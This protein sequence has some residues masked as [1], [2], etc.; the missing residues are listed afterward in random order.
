[1]EK[2]KILSDEYGFSIF[3]QVVGARRQSF[4]PAFFGLGI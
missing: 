3:Q 4:F 1:M 2:L